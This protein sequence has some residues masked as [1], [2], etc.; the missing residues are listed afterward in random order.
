[1]TKKKKKE[2]IYLQVIGNNVFKYEDEH[3]KYLTRK[4]VSGWQVE[5]Y[6][7]VDDKWVEQAVWEIKSLGG[8]VLEIEEYVS[9]DSIS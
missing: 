7:K 8:I 4:I 3:R 2:R 6:R 1:M 5:E 9:G